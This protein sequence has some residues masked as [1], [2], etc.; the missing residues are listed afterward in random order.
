MPWRLVATRGLANDGTQRVFFETR[1]RH[2]SKIPLSVPLGINPASRRK[3]TQMKWVTIK[4]AAEL[5]GYTV[6]AIDRKRQSGVWLEG[7]IWIKAPDGRILVSADAI[8]EWP[9][10]R[11]VAPQAPRRG[12]ST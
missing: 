4:N 10:R 2:V 11:M 3:I 5:S 12:S 6:K 1:K 7:I 9:E 8:D